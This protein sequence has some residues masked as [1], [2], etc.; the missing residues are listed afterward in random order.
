M[1]NNYLSLVFFFFLFALHLSTDA[2]SET[3]SSV[4]PQKIESIQSEINSLKREDKNISSDIEILRRDQVNYKIEKDLLKE[5]YSS[6][7]SMIN[8]LITIGLGLVGVL[9]YLGMRSIK[10]IKIDYEAELDKLRELKGSFEDELIGLQNKQK[11]FESQ[12]ALLAERNVE[13]D[14]RLKVLELI[15]KI[16]DLMSHQNWGWALRWADAGLAIDPK[17][18][19]L[20][21][22][23][24]RCCWNLGQLD[25]AIE[26]QIE[27]FSVEGTQSNLLNLLEL[28]AL[29]GKE[30]EF[31][32]LINANKEKIDNLDREMLIKYFKVVILIAANKKK[33]AIEL[34][35]S[36]IEKHPDQIDVKQPM[37]GNWSFSE[38][39]NCIKSMRN[40]EQQ[41]LLQQV[42]AFFSGALTP[43]ELKALIVARS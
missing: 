28:Y 40:S 29:A 1:K 7:L 42:I 30:A 34:L 43:N 12:V 8:I 26:V 14:S 15:E 39:T 19:I 20:L 25:A 24:A 4:L 18:P 37:L 23:K 21:N 41:D 31:S 32:G 2:Y 38:A 33:E 27:L 10:E 11:E 5:A 17:N 16:G 22:Q 13:Q 36:L 6:N 9:G 3:T 35:N